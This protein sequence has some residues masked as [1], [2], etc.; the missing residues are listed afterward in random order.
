[1]DV[2]KLGIVVDA[3]GARREI[4]LTSDELKH[5]ANGGAEASAVMKHL[6]DTMGGGTA[7]GSGGLVPP[8]LPPRV[9]T[10]A[11][12][13]DNMRKSASQRIDLGL[14]DQIAQV[15]Q[16]QD[17]LNQAAGFNTRYTDS[18]RKMREAAAGRGDQQLASQIEANDPFQKQAE[19]AEHARIS[20]GRLGNQITDLGTHLTGVHPIAGKVVEVLGQMALGHGVALGVIAG[21]TAIALAWDKFTESTRK[22]REEQDKLAASARDAAMTRA[23]G[24]AGGLADQA[25]AVAGRI[26]DLQEE[27]KVRSS[28]VEAAKV[29]RAQ[30]FNLNPA[31]RAKDVEKLNQELGVYQ[32]TL[33][34]LMDQIASAKLQ[35]FIDSINGPLNYAQQRGQDI[36][37]MYDS[38]IAAQNQLNKEAQSGTV[39]I[40]NQ[41]L[42]GLAQVQAALDQIRL[43]RMGLLQPPT[44]TAEG[45]R[46]DTLAGAAQQRVSDLAAL[47]ESGTSHG[48]AS[49]DQFDQRIQE[50][51]GR[52]SKLIVQSS[53]ELPDSFSVGIQKAI[54]EVNRLRD[55]LDLSRAV[56]AGGSAAEDVAASIR[57][58]A[59][60]PQGAQNNAIAINAQAQHD[61]GQQL[62]L[63]E[64]AL[65]LPDVF[66]AVR[67]ASVRLAE[68]MRDSRRK[69]DLA[70]QNWKP[71][72][73]VGGI[74]QGATDALGNVLT[75][76]SPANIAS[77]LVTGGLTSAI[78]FVEKGI[79]DLVGSIFGGGKAA[80]EAAR[81]WREAVASL[82]QSLAEFSGDDLTAALLANENQAQHLRD[83]VE[84]T[85]GWINR[86]LTMLGSSSKEYADSIATIN[87]A[88]ARRAQQIK[89]QAAQEQQYAMED[90]Q[91]RMLRAQGRTQEAD[92]L[93]FRQKQQREYNAAQAKAMQDGVID[94]SEAAYLA[95]LLQVQAAEKTAEAMGILKDALHN[96]PTGFR[97]EDYGLG[98]NY[99]G[100][101]TQTPSGNTGGGP[102]SAGP[103]APTPV[104]TSPM[105]GGDNLGNPI[106]RLPQEDRPQVPTTVVYLTVA[107]PQGG[108]QISGEETPQQIFRKTVEGL[109]DWTAQTVGGN[110]PL[111][112]GLELARYASYARAPS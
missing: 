34:S 86:I 108:I 20:I 32:N 63:R 72:N 60:S 2:A 35:N 92:D 23:L 103:V 74:K 30:E 36:S 106:N 64:Q 81:Q 65:K 98:Q 105:P 45:I 26:N 46:S 59:I 100:G 57:N 68:G 7:G 42:A 107:V 75:Q 5:L 104:P 111:A 88:E 33:K 71:G 51:Q 29:G 91:V 102:I 14:A 25:T 21:I 69:L 70:I 3:S 19:G 54:D 17:K 10:L 43:Q 94:T 15:D 67:E 93:A 83:Q 27:I 56:K 109:T 47:V 97:P 37:R 16:F 4:S 18:I 61:Y 62:A 85:M 84:E 77:D 50:L 22:A 1:M 99:Y 80:E 112:A 8:S 9:N 78:G 66:D 87:E 12:A 39:E 58:N 79:G 96:A 40:K 11:Q 38:L 13:I 89:D 6:G 31:D 73:I 44:Q 28:F 110:A 52:L 48:M 24:P 101:G 49:F 82:K 95:S 55:V 90:L 41:A 76:F 53:E